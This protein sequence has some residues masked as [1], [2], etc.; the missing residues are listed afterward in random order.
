MDL[1]TAAMILVFV[2]AA[3]AASTGFVMR[4][5]DHVAQWRATRQR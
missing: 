2:V 3:S 5:L 4:L 1:Q